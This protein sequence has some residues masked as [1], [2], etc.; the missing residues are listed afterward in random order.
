M[1]KI[2]A[3]VGPTATGKTS[4]AVAI[5]ELFPSTL[6]SADSRQVYEGMDIV[7][8]KDH[9]AKIKL[10]GIDIAK[11]GETCSVSSWYS[12]VMP[13]ISRAWK[14]SELPII[15]GGTGLYLRAVQGKITTLNTPPNHHLRTQLNKLSAHQ[16]QEKL[17]ELNPTKLNS[18]NKSDRH[19][20]R[21][22]IRAIEISLD[23][24]EAQ[25]PRPDTLTI[26]LRQPKQALSLSLIK[27]RVRFRL[28][29]GAIKETKNLLTQYDPSLPSFSA[30]GYKH[31]I[32]FISGQLTENELI[33]SWTQDEL[34]YTHRQLTWF[35]KQQNITWF[36]P[37]DPQL[38]TQVASLVKDWYH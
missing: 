26:G 12:H 23:P 25:Y 9:P 30:L 2:L 3:I 6:I 4:L 33:K 17:I 32:S 27:Q 16:L 28:K 7:T 34:A 29:L 38:V 15:V 35:N 11:P 8:G 19:N 36:D 21:R 14:N 1:S 20:P 13:I 22:L 24:G 5:S 31:L 18:M 37:S 10:H